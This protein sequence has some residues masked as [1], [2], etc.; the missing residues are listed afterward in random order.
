MTGAVPQYNNASQVPPKRLLM[1]KFVPSSR[2]QQNPQRVITS[3]ISIVASAA[4]EV[5]VVAVVVVV[6][7]M[8][9]VAQRAPA[10]Y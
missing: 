4:A 7:G 1:H 9:K 2:C 10:M 6:V 5:V 3:V 8:V